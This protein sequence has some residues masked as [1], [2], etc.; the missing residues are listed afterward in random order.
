M[1]KERLGSPRTRLFVAL[2]LPERIREAL[3]AWQRR[4][5]GDPALRPARAETLHVTLC[6]LGWQAEKSIERIAAE[7]EA[8]RPR[9]VELRF[10][11]DPVAKPPRRPALFAADAAS[12]AA[13]ELQSEVADRLEAKDFYEPEKRDFWP[14]VTLARVRSE[15]GE[16]GPSGRRRRGKPRVVETVPGPLPESVLGPFF[17]I[18][19][20]LYR[21]RLRPAGAEYAPLAGFDLPPG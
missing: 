10:A 6:F 13:I 21:S 9:P 17:G 4:E 2:D 16:K 18:R 14:H 5:C 3:G 19:V 15:R 20:T 8:V 12:E 1:A 7:I 11:A